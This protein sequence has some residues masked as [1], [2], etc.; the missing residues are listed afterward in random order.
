M[1]KLRKG[2]LKYYQ[3]MNPSELNKY[4]NKFPE[5]T[6]YVKYFLERYQYNWVKKE[7]KKGRTI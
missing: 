3:S 2:E 4:F 6:E 5:H 7:W 1:P